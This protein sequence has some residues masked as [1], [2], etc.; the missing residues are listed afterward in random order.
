MVKLGIILLTLFLAW[1]SMKLIEKICFSD[2]QEN[3]EKKKVNIFKYGFFI[4]LTILLF[5]L[6]FGS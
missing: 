5:V 3:E 1:G 2:S 6:L 4:L